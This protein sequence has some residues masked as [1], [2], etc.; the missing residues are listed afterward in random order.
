[1]NVFISDLIVDDSLVL[2]ERI[3][4]G[5]YVMAGEWLHSESIGT[6]MIVF[7]KSILLNTC[8]SELQIVVKAS[9]FIE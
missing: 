1:M 9:L 6:D 8:M 4:G 5:S 3:M 7:I 2:P